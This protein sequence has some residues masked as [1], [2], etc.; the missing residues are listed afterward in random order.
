MSG[1]F[2]VVSQKIVS[3]IYFMARIIIRIWV[4]NLEAWQSG[5]MRIEP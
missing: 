5:Q 3:K 4:R 1:I 2:G